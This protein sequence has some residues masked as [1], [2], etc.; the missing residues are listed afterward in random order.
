MN[1]KIAI[2]TGTSRLK[3]I[4]RAICIELAKNDIDIFFTFW[5]EYDKQMPWQTDDNEPDLIQAE[6]SA[7]GV[8]CEKLEFNF[9]GKEGVEALLNEV[10]N[11]LGFP[12]IL[13]NN[14][15]YSTQTSIDTITAE[16]LDKHYTVNF[17]VPALLTAEFVKQ[18]QGHKNGRIIN[19][20]SGQTLSFMSNEVAYATTKGAIETLTRTISQEIAKKGITINAVNPGLTD[21]GWLD[22]KQKRIFSERFP[23]G[24]LG[25]PEDVAKLISFLVSENA[26]WITGQ[27][28]HSE[29]GF[30]REHYGS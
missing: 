19:L 8:R 5:S 21:T 12:T 16:E 7:L 9:L 18:Y 1:R 20:T 11:K 4:G 3:G 25:Q 13:V 30:V 15:T 17:K 23:M 22:E 27:V 28:I 6:I 10:K 2:V 29:G 14:A 26:E 24:R